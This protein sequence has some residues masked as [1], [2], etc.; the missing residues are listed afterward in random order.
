M[1]FATTSLPDD[2]DDR[3]LEF[4]SDDW[5]YRDSLVPPPDAWIEQEFDD[6]A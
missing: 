6:T 1:L 4:G 5:Q 3:L 2:L